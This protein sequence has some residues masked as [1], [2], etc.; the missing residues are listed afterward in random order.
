MK[1][2]R[3]A[4]LA[5]PSGKI[6]VSCPSNDSSM[7]NFFD[8]QPQ[9]SPGFYPVF[10]NVVRND[11]GVAS[12]FVIVVFKDAEITS[13]EEV[14]EFFTD[15]GD[16]CIFDTSSTNLLLDIKKKMPHEAWG[17]FKTATL[18]DGDGSLILDDTSRVNAIVFRCGDWAY[19]CFVGYDDTNEVTCLV[20][21]GRISDEA[22]KLQNY[23]LDLMKSK[24]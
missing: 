12:A 22:H 9:I 8:T 18:F 10:I 16:G 2:R 17:E 24:G 7:C 11:P 14:G 6:S 21:D 1:R 4:N 5:L 20:V 15:T 23:I 13:W 19:K 3:L